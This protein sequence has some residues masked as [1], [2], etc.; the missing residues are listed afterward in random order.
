[1]AAGS[2]KLETLRQYYR[3]P[4]RGAH[5]ALGK[6]ETMADLMAIVLRPVAEKCGLDTWEKLTAFAT[7]EWYPNR[8]AFGK[9]KG[10]CVWDAREDTILRAWLDWLTTSPNERSASMGRWYLRYLE[11]AEQGE[12]NIALGATDMPLAEVQRSAAPAAGVVVYVDPEAERL[13][14][15]IAAARARLAELEATYTVEKSKSD[16]VQAALF[17]K[18]A[19]H[20]QKRDALRLV[21]IYRKKFLDSLLGGGEKKAE[22]AGEEF[23]QAKAQSEREYGATAAAM[24]NRRELSGADADEI[25]MLWR[26]LVKLHH[27]DRFADE[28]G[29]L[30]SYEKLCSAIN[31]ARDSGDLATLRAIANDPKEFVFQHGWGS[32]D[33]ND[34]QQIAQLRRLWES[35]EREIV[36]VLEAT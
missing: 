18:M 36:S 6:V 26:K 24:E 4:E 8:I 33:F 10:R 16:A 31:H 23:R 34:G 5:A 7:E 1:M 28:P 29:R 13:A 22:Q 35:L 9:H 15:L 12:A 30:E 20:Y 17:K 21:V 19:E 11:R 3:L 2:C 27:P 32:L 25:S 14:T